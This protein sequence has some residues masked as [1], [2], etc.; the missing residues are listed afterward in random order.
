MAAGPLLEGAITDG[1]RPALGEEPLRNAFV[2]S[3]LP[4][5][6]ALWCFAAARRHMAAETA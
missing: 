5:A 4:S 2:C 1:L 3:T 6:A